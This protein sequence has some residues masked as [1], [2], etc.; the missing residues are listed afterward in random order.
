MRKDSF[1]EV[2]G[3]L[4]LVIFKKMQLLSNAWRVHICYLR[5]RHRSIFVFN[6]YIEKRKMT[7]ESDFT[8]WEPGRA[9]ETGEA[10]PSLNCLLQILATCI[11][12]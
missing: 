8:T 5:D 2:T 12:C 9:G 6:L 7:T 10:Y 3:P 1:A 4:E 11:Q